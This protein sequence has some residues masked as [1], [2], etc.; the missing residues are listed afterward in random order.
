MKILITGGAGFIGSHLVDRLVA[1]KHEVRI[2]DNM[3]EQVHSTALWPTY[4]NYKADMRYGDVRDR[5]FVHA[6]LEGVDVVYHLAAKVGVGQ[7]MYQM[8]E[9]VDVNTR[10]TA[11]L[12]EALA[13]SSVKRLI[14]ASSM[15]IYGEQAIADE[16]HI[17]QLP[18]VYAQTKYDQE[19]LCLIFGKAYH[20]PTVALRFFNVY[21]PRQSLS[22]PYTGVM[23]IFASRLLNNH[24][25]LIYEDGQ[26][27]RDFVH[28]D[29]VAHACEL[30]LT[31][32]HTGTVFNVGTGKATTL[33]DL[34]KS[35]A[36]V[37]GKSIEPVITHQHRA[38]DIRHCVA[39]T[40]KAKKMLGFEA[41]V[42]LAQGL[43]GYAQWVKS[44]HAVDKV[45][46]AHEELKQR[47][48]AT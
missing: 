7:S 9:Y 33:Y 21:G 37:M 17:P 14:V 27:T 11:V 39:S 22:N 12:L 45:D 8:A 16:W 35:L 48:L 23:A 25:P 28:V 5:E 15:S 30:A 43:I 41:R 47:G 4:A 1:A 42:T 2:L 3:D 32:E 20:I 36:A 34:A 10:G 44:Q 38:G 13:K 19:R 24:S 6:V 26:Q 40:L 18:N 31:T 29:D 46:E